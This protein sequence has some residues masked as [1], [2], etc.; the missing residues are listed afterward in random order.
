[1]RKLWLLAIYLIFT[2]PAQARDAG[3]FV[4][5]KSGPVSSAYYNEA[6]GICRMVNRNRKNYNIRC[7]VVPEYFR[8]NDLGQLEERNNNLFILGSNNWEEMYSNHL[9]DMRLL[10]SL[11]SDA[12]MV[13]VKNTAKIT[14][15]SQLTPKLNILSD[16]NINTQIVTEALLKLYQLDQLN[17]IRQNLKNFNFCES[18]YDVLIVTESLPSLYLSKLMSLCGL[19]ILDLKDDRIDNVVFPL[20]SYLHW[21]Q[22]DQHSFINLKQPVTTIGTRTVLAV[23][24]DF[25]V[26]KAYNLAK[27]FLENYGAIANSSP[28]LVNITDAQTVEVLGKLPFHLG[29]QKFIT[30]WKTRSKK[31]TLEDQPTADD[32]TTGQK[33]INKT[34]VSTETTTMD[35]PAD[36]DATTTNTTATEE[37]IVDDSSYNTPTNDTIAKPATEI[38]H[39]EDAIMNSLS[40]Q[41][42]S[43]MKQNIEKYNI[44]ISQ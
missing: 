14:K 37:D 22:L 15:F 41:K 42:E 29:A 6:I 18:K 36:T 28:N 39:D 17:I 8:A 4:S 21:H 13:L 16:K 25:T 23:H 9:A 35:K 24:K 2:L 20:R 11:H 40:S 5:I 1:M 32:H 30:E 27:I 10:L 44:D 12:Y 43:D 33:A 7:S 3:S 34:T 38:V 19:S 31:D 26:D